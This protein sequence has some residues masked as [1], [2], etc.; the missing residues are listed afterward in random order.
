MQQGSSMECGANQEQK[1]VLLLCTVGGS[2]EPVTKAVLRHR[3]ARVVF[4]CSQQTQSLVDGIARAVKTEWPEWNEGCYDLRLIDDHEDI[5]AC[6]RGIRLILRDCRRDQRWHSARMIIDITGGTKPMAA[7]L[8]SAA[9]L[10]ECEVSYVGGGQRDNEGVGAVESGHERMVRSAHPWL[11]TGY[12]SVSEAIAFFNACDY[13]AASQALDRGRSYV[14]PGSSLK[15]EM[16]TLQRFCEVFHLWDVFQHGQAKQKL[17]RFLPQLNNLVVV[18]CGSQG[19]VPGGMGPLL[20]RSLERLEQIA[21]EDRAFLVEDLIA[22]AERRIDNGRYDDALA[23]LYRAV[24]AFGQCR[25]QAHGV[26]S[27]KDV[28]LDT[29]P[30]RL[31]STLE[32]Q[33][34][35]G[36]VDIAMQHAWRWLKELNDE[37][38]PRFAQLGFEGQGG[39]LGERNTSILAHGFKPVRKEMVAELLKNVLSLIGIEAHSLFQFPQIEEQ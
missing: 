22:N 4:I 2:P 9:S 30:P 16:E 20:R 7:A 14:P 37:A 10:F 13:A 19:P 17:E 5:D 3:P 39:K 35:N 8:F 1:L 31:R 12:R 21:A 24:E 33:S 15:T 28:P 11:T 23:R 32:A 34:Q 25:L 38:A 36:K 18:P 29:I 27:T 26:P 6:F